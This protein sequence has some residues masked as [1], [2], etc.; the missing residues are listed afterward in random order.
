MSRQVMEATGALVSDEKS[1][2]PKAG[3]TVVMEAMAAP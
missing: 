2:S 3:L 1:L